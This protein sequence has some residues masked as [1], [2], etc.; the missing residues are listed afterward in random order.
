[1]G[2]SLFHSSSLGGDAYEREKQ[3]DG[4]GKWLHDL[5]CLWCALT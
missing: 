4:K 1:M 3:E 5:T 2:F